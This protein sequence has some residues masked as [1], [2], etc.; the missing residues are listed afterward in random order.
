MG[1]R[2]E[3]GLNGLAGYW[4]GWSE[5]ATQ[6]GEET[7]EVVMTAGMNGDVVVRQGVHAPHLQAQVVRPMPHEGYAVP[8]S[9]MLFR[10]RHASCFTPVEMAFH[11]DWLDPKPQHTSSEV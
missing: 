7:P 11:K 2:V 6:G 10:F 8:V 3:I 4:V 1:P 5:G 9:S